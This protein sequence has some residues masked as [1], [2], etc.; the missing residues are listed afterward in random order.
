VIRLERRIEVDRPAAEIFDR[1]TRVE[2]IPR[3]LPAIVEVA[4]TSPGGIAAGSTLRIVVDTPGRPTEAI[5]RVVG[6]EPPERMALEATA[7]SSAVRADVVVVPVDTSRSAV[8]IR[9]EI[10]LGGMLRFVEGMARARVEAEAPEAEA[11]V[12]RWLESD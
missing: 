5:G 11:A 6:F 7:G 9:T 3:W 4:V 1:L 2:E 10:V 8:E 12:R